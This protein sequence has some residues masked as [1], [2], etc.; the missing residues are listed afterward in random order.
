M[1]R[2]DGSNSKSQRSLEMYPSSCLRLH[3][4]I[5]N[6][7]SQGERRDHD[8]TSKEI[9]RGNLTAKDVWKTLKDQLDRQESY[10]LPEALVVLMTLMGLRPSFWTQRK[11]LESRKHLSMEIIKKDLRQETSRL[12]AE[13][14]QQPQG[15]LAVN[16][17]K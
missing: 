11:T 1:E 6:A 10:L 2:G 12:K 15:H 16:F 13:Q 17:T 7:H 4:K 3:D 8:L 9:A 5:W 14:A